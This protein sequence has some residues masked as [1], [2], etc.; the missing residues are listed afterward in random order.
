M[1]RSDTKYRQIVE[2]ALQLSNEVGMEA[3]SLGSL[4]TAIGMSKSGV[5]AHFKSKEALQLAVVE[6]A[7]ARF[8]AVVLQPVLQLPRG[9]ARL[10]GLL[11]HYLQ[12][13]HGVQQGSCFFVAQSQEFDD[14]PG[15]LRDALAQAVRDWRDAVARIAATAIDP[16]RGCAEQFAF[17]FIGLTM[18]YQLADKLLQDAQA[19]T[20]LQAA[21]DA[22]L[23][24]YGV[25]PCSPAA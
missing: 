17:E 18:T 13:L 8:V 15:P 16:A 24:R 6:L 10:H 21:F 4:A 22:L 14:R 9:A 5:F 1:K 12:W 23:Q 3:L 25:M 19:D 7:V 2:H 11:H 20:R